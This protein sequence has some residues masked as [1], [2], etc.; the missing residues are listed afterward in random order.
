MLEDFNFIKRAQFENHEIYYTPKLK[1]EQIKTNFF[2]HKEKSRN[3]IKY[4][5]ANDTGITKTRLSNDLKMHPNT[6]AKYLKILEEYK[7]ITKENHSNSTLF[8]LNE[9]NLNNLA[10]K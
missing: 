10:I 5:N 3:I 8:F 7:I 4:L 2:Y 1:L 6:V 9:D